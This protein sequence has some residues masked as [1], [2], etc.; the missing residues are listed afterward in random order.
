ME[1]RTRVIY[2]NRLN[3]KLNEGYPDRQISEEGQR[4]HQLK[5]CDNKNKDADISLIENNVN[6][7][8]LSPQKGRHN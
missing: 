2:S 6:D 3:K 8:K 1:N 7:D 5:H 4:T